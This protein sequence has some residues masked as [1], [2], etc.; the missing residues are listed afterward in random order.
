MSFPVGTKTWS[1]YCFVKIKAKK[2][3]GIN[4]I[5]EH[6]DVGGLVAGVVAA[7]ERE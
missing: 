7:R 2:V 4:I 6:F 1:N 5:V 3:E